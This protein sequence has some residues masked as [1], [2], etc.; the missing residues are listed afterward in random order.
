MSEASQLANG[1]DALNLEDSDFSLGLAM[2][3]DD[4]ADK[5]TT[6]NGK[7]DADAAREQLEAEKAAAYEE[8]LT[9]IFKAKEAKTN[10]KRRQSH[11][12]A[13]ETTAYKRARLRKEDG[14]AHKTRYRASVSEKKEI[15]DYR[16][17]T[18]DTPGHSVSDTLRKFDNVDYSQLKRW[19][20][21]YAGG[22]V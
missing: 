14:S 7:S 20:K 18:K 10:R 15:L 12:P 13:P 22:M 8:T 6:A 11:D 19:S 3:V 5:S 17:G 9:A 4:L 1:V 21:K 16:W 2:A